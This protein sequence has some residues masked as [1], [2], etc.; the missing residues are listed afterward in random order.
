ME[1]QP[2]GLAEAQPE[3]LAEAQ[4]QRLRESELSELAAQRKDF[5]MATTAPDRDTLELEQ[6]LETALT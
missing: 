2:E 3:R 6:L 5:E 1:A 4:H